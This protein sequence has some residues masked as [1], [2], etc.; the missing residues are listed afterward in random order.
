V[1]L[2]P[3]DLTGAPAVRAEVRLAAA[4]RFLAAREI[5]LLPSD[6]RCLRLACL[7]IIGGFFTVRAADS[8]LILAFARMTD[9]FAESSIAR[10]LRSFAANWS[11]TMDSNASTL[12][13][14]LR[15]FF[16]FIDTPGQTK[17]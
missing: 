6:V 12:L 10:T 7:A 13:N 1:T 4:Q 5:L 17:S 8:E 14:L 11:M 16:A 9:A 3:A 2:S 15:A